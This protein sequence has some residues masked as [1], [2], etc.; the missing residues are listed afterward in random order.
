MPID[1]FYMCFD[2]EKDVGLKKDKTDNNIRDLTAGQDAVEAYGIEETTISAFKFVVEDNN[3][4]LP[5]T[6]CDMH[7]FQH[8]TICLQTFPT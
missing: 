1:T 8:L 7:G 4:C 2:D 5:I 6:P 3:F